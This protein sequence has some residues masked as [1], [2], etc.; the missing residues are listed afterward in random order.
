MKNHV[1]VDGIFQ[2]GAEGGDE[3]RRQIGQEAN[4]VDEE[5]GDARGSAAFVEGNVQRCE[6]TILEGES[7]KGFSV[8]FV[9]FC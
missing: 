6:K 8:N 3:K 4:R 2:S 1:G 9:N 7:A 5:V